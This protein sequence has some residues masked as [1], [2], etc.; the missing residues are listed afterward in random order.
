MDLL[1]NLDHP[2][3]LENAVV[4]K[5]EVEIFL[6]ENVREFACARLGLLHILVNG[7]FGHFSVQTGAQ[8]DEALG[9]IP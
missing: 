2:L 5:L 1:E 6:L 4:L 7:F 9:I 8:S 3:L